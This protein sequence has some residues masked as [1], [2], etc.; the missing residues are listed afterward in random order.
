M[1][2][3]EKDITQWPIHDVIVRGGYYPIIMLNVS[4]LKQNWLLCQHTFFPSPRGCMPITPFGVRKIQ[5]Y[6]WYCLSINL[7]LQLHLVIVYKN[8]SHIPGLRFCLTDTRFISDA[9]MRTQIQK[10][11]TKYSYANLLLGLNEK[12]K[13]FEKFN[14]LKQSMIF[15]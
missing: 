9:V 3:S 5:R 1:Q 4:M 15:L 10:G 14:V 13:R 11:F 6:L 12:K 7:V 2:K 8:S